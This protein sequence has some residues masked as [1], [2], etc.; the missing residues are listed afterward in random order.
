MIKETITFGLRNILS[1]KLFSLINILGSAIGIT[2]AFFIT[3]WVINE[4]SFDK[5]TLDYKNIYLLGW[6]GKDGNN[7][8]DGSPYQLSSSVVQNIP[9]VVSATKFISADQDHKTIHI[10]NR[11]FELENGVYVDS[12]WFHIINYKVQKG[13]IAGFSDFGN[14]IVISE[15]MADKYFGKEN[16]IGKTVIIDS[17]ACLVQAVVQDPATNN[18]FKFKVFLPAALHFKKPT[19]PGNQDSWKIFD[20]Y[21]FV[22]TRPGAASSVVSR[23]ISGLMAHA[24]KDGNSPSLVRLDE[25]HFNTDVRIPV[26]QHG[27]RNTVFIFL[28][29][30]LLILLISSINYINFVTASASLR[31]KEV[32]VKKICGAGRLSLFWQFLSESLFINFLSVLITII[33]V[34]CLLPYFNRFTGYQFSV[35]SFSFWVELFAIFGITTLLM[36]IYPSVVLSS[37]SYLSLNSTRYTA[38]KGAGLRKALLTFQFIVSILLI[39]GV[40]VMV[41][42]LKFVNTDGLTFNRSEIVSVPV[43]SESL[44]KLDSRKKE[45]LINLLRNQLMQHAGIEN[46][47]VSSQSVINLNMSMSGIASWA[48]KKQSFDPAIYPFFVDPNFNT[49]FNLTL[50]E[51]RW[52]GKNLP[53]DRHNYI[54]N[55]T[56][57]ASFGLLKPYIGQPFAVFGD[58]GKIIGIVKDFH[59]INF[60][61]KIAPLV[62]MDRPGSGGTF[63][64]KMKSANARNVM[65]DIEKIWNNTFPQTPFEFQFLDESFNQLYQAELKSFALIGYFSFIAILLTSI[66]LYG[67]VTF[68]LQKKTKE[69]GIRK[70]LGASVKNIVVSLSNEFIRLLVLACFI[71]LPLAWWAMNKWLEGFAYR[72]SLSAWILLLGLVPV[73]FVTCLVIGLRVL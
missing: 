40:I 5:N 20:W 19:G 51:G 22:Q 64:I 60:Y 57:V 70:V 29:L 16:P 45:D 33:L 61:E 43:N 6:S 35:L 14:G 67:L 30:G 39:A 4:F 53:T 69:I 73:I 37:I 10:Q 38:L 3:I 18:S 66:G 47:T 52:F 56:S 50:S 31:S 2:S 42:Q 15:S 44:N 8:W 13:S 41:R 58:T 7:K 12:N 48:G 36:G 17:N 59:F 62:M 54:L 72:I 11:A 71:S 1:R 63:F 25:I 65:T 68:T 32:S 24:N 34:L 46:V 55:E 21:T 9:E 26:L 49:V 28:S 23:K 27:N